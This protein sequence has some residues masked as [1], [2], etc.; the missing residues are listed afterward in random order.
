MLALSVSTTF[1]A[2]FFLFSFLLHQAP[3]VYNNTGR[4]DKEEHAGFL[5]GLLEHGKS[6]KVRFA[7]RRRQRGHEQQ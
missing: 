3:V 7:H 6:F 4:W 5:K 2:C 1:S